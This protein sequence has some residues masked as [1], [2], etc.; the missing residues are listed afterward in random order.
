MNDVKIS[1]SE[2]IRKILTKSTAKIISDATGIGL[3]SIKKL[4]SGERFVEK[5][6]LADAIKLTD[7]A[8]K[9]ISAE[10]NIWK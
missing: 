1:S 4:K 9:N 2:L 3:S 8:K 10:I 6:N 7:F 5:M